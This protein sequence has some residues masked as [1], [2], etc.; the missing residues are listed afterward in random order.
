MDV[1]GD[2]P[3]G[4]WMKSFSG[5][6][7]KK[8]LA[9]GALQRAVIDTDSD[10]NR[11]Q[12]GKRRRVM[13]KFRF[14]LVF[15]IFF[16]Y[17]GVFH[18]LS[19]AKEEFPTRPITLMD[20]FAPGGLGEMQCRLLAEFVGKY[21]GQRVLV[22]SRGGMSGGIMVTHLT[23]QKPDGYSIARMPAGSVIGNPF[24]SKV[25]YSYKDLTYLLA[26]GRQQHAVS[27]R[28]DAP[29]KTFDEL[30][31]YAKKNPGKIR[32]GTYSAISTTSFIMRMIG[33]DRQIDW[34]HVPYKS[35]GQ[36]AT[37][38]LGG[39][40]EVCAVASGQLPYVTSGQ[41]RLLAVFNKKRSTEFPDIPSIYELGY[42]V[43]LLSDR[44]TL[45]G[46][47]APKGLTGEPFEKLVSA[48]Q[49]ATRE[50]AFQKMMQQLACPIEVLD[51]KEYEREILESYKEF[52]KIL[53]P[54]V[55]DVQ[56]Q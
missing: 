33:K 22:E 7:I 38:T 40:V 26:F 43:P 11:F 45:T 29:W 50:P 20:G 55:K 51:S 4:V 16:C 53:P 44:S 12:R 8:E 39:H 21:L 23:R 1:R 31:E 6:G 52:E 34:I 25:E 10:I 24:T 19:F 27:V 37:S 18:S 36:A 49:R 42:Q 35:D 48:F 14:P 28:T 13:K 47:V 2:F 3:R 56:T 46:I 32:Y 30:V 15:A 9:N 54:L 41:L 5:E 17:L